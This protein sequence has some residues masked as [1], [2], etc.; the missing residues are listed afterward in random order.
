MPGRRRPRS[1]ATRKLV[2]YRAKAAPS[3][4]SQPLRRS[5]TPADDRLGRSGRRSLSR[6]TGRPGSLGASRPSFDPRLSVAVV[7][8]ARAAAELVAVARGIP[9]L[10]VDRVEMWAQAEL[11]FTLP[12]SRL[13]EL[14]DCTARVSA[15][16]FTLRFLAPP[17]RHTAPPGPS[18]G[19]RQRDSPGVASTY[20]VAAETQPV[21]RCEEDGTD[22]TVARAPVADAPARSPRPARTTASSRRIPVG[23][24]F[25]P[26]ATASAL[27]PRAPT[28]PPKAAPPETDAAPT[29]SV[30]RL[31]HSLSAS[32]AAAAEAAS[33][34]TGDA[35]IQAPMQF[36]HVRDMQRQTA[37]LCSWRRWEAVV[38][39]G[40]VPGMAWLLDHKHAKVDLPVSGRRSA[41][42]IAA[43]RLD[44]AAVRFLLSRGA[45][46]SCRDVHDLRPVDVGRMKVARAEAVV[47]ATPTAAAA[48]YLRLCRRCTAL[49]SGVS[50]H[51]AAKDGDLDHVRALLET[52]AVAGPDPRNAYGMTPLHLAVLHSRNRV[53]E[54]LLGRGAD[55]TARNARGQSPIFLATDPMLER[56]LRDAAKR[57]DA[58]KRSIRGEGER[59]G[60]KWAG[61]S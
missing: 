7:V 29:G 8:P 47:R 37:C 59:E 9:R 15:Q 1:V 10:Q 42:H 36:R 12:R 25:R 30:H 14:T 32:A 41:L 26:V 43:E 50:I 56:L 3:P 21:E 49:L 18:V 61:C 60:R 48:S 22:E 53:A 2:D 35:T 17:S 5:Q 16:E 24:L 4:L 19:S 54:Y 39:A 40:Y 28:A 33:S 45:D 11:H 58:L 27:P 13:G 38:A 6:T 31:G 52:G 55:P 34:Q 51:R 20:D 46:V 57:M 44:C 23:V